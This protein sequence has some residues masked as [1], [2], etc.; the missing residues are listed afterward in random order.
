M[1]RFFTAL[2]FTVSLSSLLLAEDWRVWR[3]PTLDNHTPASAIES[4]P[5]SWSETEN[6]LWRSPIPGSCHATPI[7]VGK[8]IFVLTHEPDSKTI[9][10]LQYSLDD[11]KQL[12]H[13]VLHEDVEPPSYM[14]KKNTCAPGTPSSDGKTVFV[15][16]Q[17]NDTIQASAISLDGEILWQRTVAPYQQSSKFWFGY[18]ASPLLLQDSLVVAVDTDNE[19]SGLYALAKDSGEQVWKTPRP[20]AAS[21]SSPILATIDGRRQI[22]ISGGSVVASYDPNSGEQIWAVTATSDVTCGTIVWK[23]S[24][25]FASGGYPDAG[26]FGIKV[27]G[28]NAEVVWQNKAKCYEQSMLVA[29]E[30]VYGIANSGVGYCWRASDGKQ[31]WRQR[32][33]GPHSASPLLIGDRI[34]ASDERGETL[35][36]QASP[37]DFMQ[38]AS[39][40]L[41]D[42][43]FASPVYAD[44]KLLLRHAST[45]SGERKEFLYAI[46]KSHAT[47]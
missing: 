17:V 9:S 13:V 8:K 21:Y 6:I 36:F 30:F 23:D 11:G 18:G 34:Y 46:G 47:P 29:G 45:E 28:T 25:V 43:S 27:S 19:E 4:I 44:G 22:L 31:M 16:A 3:G 42:S 20:Q 15:A 37:D 38:L 35:V 24:M 7:V 41:G 2:L 10:L 40:R 12:G 14:H 1:I 26:T 32:I 33:K 39:N 5:V